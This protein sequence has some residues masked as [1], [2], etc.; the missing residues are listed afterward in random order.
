MVESVRDFG[1]GILPWVA[2][3]LLYYIN[4]NIEQVRM[5]LR[6]LRLEN[7][8]NVKWQELVIGS[9]FDTSDYAQAKPTDEAAR[10]SKRQ[11]ENGADAA[12]RLLQFS[13]RQKDS[14]TGGPYKGHDPDNLL[15]S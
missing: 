5:E 13:P 6:R 10:K 15:N 4:S 2:I 14:A 9:L 11:F 1:Y 8:K 7:A 3:A 12:P